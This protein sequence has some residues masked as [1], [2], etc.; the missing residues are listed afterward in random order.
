MAL[1]PCHCLFQTYAA[2]RRLSL[3]PYQRPADIFLGVR[4]FSGVAPGYH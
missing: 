3:Q 4:Y 2:G 1:S